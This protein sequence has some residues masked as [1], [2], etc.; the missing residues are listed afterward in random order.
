MIGQESKCDKKNFIFRGGSFYDSHKDKRNYKSLP[1]EDCNT[2]IVAPAH[3]NDS[4]TIGFHVFQI[5]ELATAAAFY[6]RGRKAGA[7]RKVFVFN[8]GDG[9]F[10][11][12]MLTEMDLKVHKAY[13]S[14]ADTGEIL[15]TR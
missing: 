3:L 13:K 9:T 8:L 5:I 7:K 15:I 14:R 12:S 1:W 4:R 2:V 6:R 10:V 11:A